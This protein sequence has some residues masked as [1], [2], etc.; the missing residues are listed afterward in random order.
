MTSFVDAKLGELFPRKCF[1]P[2]NET[3]RRRNLEGGKLV[4]KSYT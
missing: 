2:L 1:D 4:F 3:A